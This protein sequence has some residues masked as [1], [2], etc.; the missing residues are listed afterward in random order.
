MPRLQ[1]G[2]RSKTA[3]I[4][5]YVLV[6]AA[7]MSLL[8]LGTE[9]LG[10]HWQWYRIP[11]YLFTRE[12]S[13]FIPGP[14]LAGLLVTFHITAVSLLAAFSV[15]LITALLRLSGSLAAKGLSRAYLEF[16]RNT[17]LL[18]QLLFIYFV[19]SP[20]FGLSAFASAV[21]G[22]S[23]FEGAYIS[24][25]IR[26]GIV[27]IHK[28]QWEASYSLGLT[29]MQTYSHIILPQALRRVL[30]PLTG[31]AISLIKDSSLVSVIAIYDLTMRAEV[32]VSETFLSFEIWFTV[33]AIYL[34]ITAM[35][36]AGAHALEM[37]MKGKFA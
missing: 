18:T 13:H 19:V 27:S 15:G 22:L 31:Q 10:Y 17:P 20:V 28:G 7:S 29:T 32:I 8:Y 34:I 26:A 23:L 30:P 24:E 35:L 5:M 36:S 11:R 2:T 14:L 3:D 6:M 4:G 25:I 33:A 9:R 16:F 12:G 21:L 1:Q 37:R